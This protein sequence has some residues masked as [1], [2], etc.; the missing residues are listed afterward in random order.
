ML[1][2]AEEA[3]FTREVLQAGPAIVAFGAA[4]CGHCRRLTP[5][6]EQLARQGY[7]VV[8][9]DVDRSPALAQRY[10]VSSLP[11]LLYFREGHPGAPLV[12]PGSLAQIELW[13]RSGQR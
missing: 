9:V 10:G 13:L 12:G 2:Q 6:L 11:T 5:A 3:S 1:L 8:S 4:W 7:R